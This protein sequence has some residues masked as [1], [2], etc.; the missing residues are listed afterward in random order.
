MQVWIRHVKAHYK[1][2]DEIF[3]DELPTKD[4]LQYFVKQGIALDRDK[5][6]EEIIKQLNRPLND[7]NM[8]SF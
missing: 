2:E 7:E 3:V 4:I 1:R 8:I 6:R 5:A